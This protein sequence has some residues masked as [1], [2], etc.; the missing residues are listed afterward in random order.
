MLYL[1]TKERLIRMPKEPR[2]V[3]QIA[4]VLALIIFICSVPSAGA[5]ESIESIVSATTNETVLNETVTESLTETIPA[6]TTIEPTDEIT[7]ESTILTPVTT[8]IV[9]TPVETIDIEPAISAEDGLN[10]Q[11]S[12]NHLK[13][14][15]GAQDLTNFLANNGALKSTSIIKR[16]LLPIWDL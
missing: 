10:D 14:G 4:I 12:V 16:A 7:P 11:I 2:L 9:A 6:E 1:R 5:D 8:L 15:T 13:I 3:Y